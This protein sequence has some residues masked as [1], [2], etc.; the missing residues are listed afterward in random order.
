MLL[1]MDSVNQMN[2]SLKGVD[3]KGDLGLI[4]QRPSRV[5][6]FLLPHMQ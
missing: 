4:D 6:Q 3:L 1:L 2:L 5:D